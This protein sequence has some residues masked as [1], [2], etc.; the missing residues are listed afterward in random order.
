M[1]ITDPHLR[2]DIAKVYVKGQ[3]FVRMM[4]KFIGYEHSLYPIWVFWKSVC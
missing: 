1:Y 2:T 3:I 4:K